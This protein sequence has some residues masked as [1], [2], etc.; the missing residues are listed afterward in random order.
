M[1]EVSQLALQRAQKLVHRVHGQIRKLGGQCRGQ[2]ALFIQRDKRSLSAT[3]EL[4]QHKRN[5]VGLTAHLLHGCQR[6]NGGALLGEIERDVDDPGH[7]RD[8]SARKRK[9]GSGGIAVQL[10]RVSDCHMQRFRR[11]SVQ[12]D[13]I[14]RYHIL[15]LDHAVER[16]FLPAHTECEDGNRV[17]VQRGGQHRERPFHASVAGQR[18]DYA[19]ALVNHRVR[20]EGEGAT[21]AHAHFVTHRSEHAVERLLHA[22]RQHQH[23]GQECHRDRQREHREHG[24]Q[25]MADDISKCDT[26]HHRP[27]TSLMSDLNRYVVAREPSTTPTAEA[28]PKASAMCHPSIEEKTRLV[29][30]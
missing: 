8:Q 10:Q 2:C 27:S 19:A 1:L 7:A 15:A 16:L 12:Q 5:C 11:V 23:V 4:G 28:M 21:R 26:H 24:A 25:A 18:G 6:Q 13:V 9:R 30:K 22:A 17:H 29:E 14:F 3:R 20:G